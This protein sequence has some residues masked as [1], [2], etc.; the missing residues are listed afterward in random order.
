MAT[1]KNAFQ[2]SQ[3]SVTTV[4]V[5]AKAMCSKEQTN[6]ARKQTCMENQ[7]CTGDV[8][9]GEGSKKQDLSGG[10]GNTNS[11]DLGQPSSQGHLSSQGQP[12]SQGT[13]SS[14]TKYSPEEIERKKQLALAKRKS[15][16]SQQI[17]SVKR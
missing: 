6:F 5:P 10:Q 12:C 3:C 16:A 9:L 2:N 4:A 1:Q 14:Q 11:S 7:A 13:T 15:R 17:G 8:I